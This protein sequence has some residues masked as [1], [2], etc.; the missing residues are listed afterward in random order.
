M[1]DD[2]DNA[3]ND[4]EAL[5]G[6]SPMVCSSAKVA[7]SANGCWCAFDLARSLKCNIEW[8]LPVQ[9]NLCI[10][11]FSGCSTV[12]MGLQVNALPC[13]IPWEILQDNRLDVVQ[14]YDVL[15]DLFLSGR[16]S[17]AMFETPCS[18]QSMARLPPLRS[19]CE[20]LGRMDLSDHQRQLVLQGNA[21]AAATI[22]LCTLLWE[23]NKYFCVEN[24]QRSFL[25][26]NPGM[27]V[28]AQLHGVAFVQIMM[29][30]SLHVMQ[31][32]HICCTTCH[33]CTG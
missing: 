31:R 24:P 23:I 30:V 11:L 12:T 4:D 15:Q 8:P 28:L 32:A 10:E 13:C 9:A 29:R 27:L 2:A 25:W 21:M 6:A 5:F 33:R 14:N 17:F 20:P 19:W 16:I 18:S 1:P 7:R 26:A 22:Q 3:V